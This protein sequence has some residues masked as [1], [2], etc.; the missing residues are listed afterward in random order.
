MKTIKFILLKMCF[1]SSMI[2]QIFY[3]DPF[4]FLVHFYIRKRKGKVNIFLNYF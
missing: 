1:L 3:G 2:Y 4:N